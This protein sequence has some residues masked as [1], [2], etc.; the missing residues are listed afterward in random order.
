MKESASEIE[1]KATAEQ[2]ETYTTDELKTLYEYA[3]P[4]E[5]C[6]MLLGV[7]LRIRPF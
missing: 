5:R 7:E 6:L 4:L 1:D 3:T 2:V